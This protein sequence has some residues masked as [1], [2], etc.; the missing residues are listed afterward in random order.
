MQ[1]NGQAGIPF[2]ADRYLPPSPL[3]PSHYTEKFK[4]NLHIFRNY[5]NLRIYYLF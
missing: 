2:F 5:K 4:R 3:S 1:E